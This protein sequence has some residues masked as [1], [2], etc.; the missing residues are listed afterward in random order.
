MAL[1]AN[2]AQSP[3][4]GSAVPLEIDHTRTGT[5]AKARK[6]RAKEDKIPKQKETP[7]TMG[8]PDEKRQ[9]AS[10]QSLWK[11]GS[12]GPECIQSTLRQV[13]QAERQSVESAVQ[14]SQVPQPALPRAT[15]GEKGDLHINLDEGEVAEPYV[16]VVLQHCLGMT[17]SDGGDEGITCGGSGGGCS[18][19]S[20]HPPTRR[21]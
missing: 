8:K 5:K 4:A 2:T 20:I 14:D 21:T 16:R 3:D 13:S 12:W 9:R 15:K 6:K 11:R 17:Y 18:A 7:R 1:A 19:N 10:L